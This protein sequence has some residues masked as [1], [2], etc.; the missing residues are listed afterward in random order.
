[1]GVTMRILED[2]YEEDF[3]LVGIHTGLDDYALAYALNES[4]KIRLRRTGSDLA[5]SS[6][7]SYPFF[8]WKNEL[9]DQN[10]AL[11]TNSCITSQKSHPGDLF[12]EEPSY[13]NHHLLPEHKGVN[14]LLK[15]DEEVL[16]PEMLNKIKAIP[17]VITAYVIQTENLK[18]KPNL[19]F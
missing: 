11:L 8:E 1:M 2:S 16:R 5:F 10:W 17:G 19:I 3:A 6:E 18:S 9:Y 14:F 13:S 12:P 4:L 7:V 15:T